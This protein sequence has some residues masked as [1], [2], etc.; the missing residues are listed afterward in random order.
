MSVKLTAPSSAKKGTS[1]SVSVKVTNTLGYHSSF[2][3]EIW[4]EATRIFNK[5]EII[6]DGQSKT[7]SDSFIMPASDVTVLAWVERWIFDHWGYY[8]AD[9]ELVELYTPPPPEPE[10]EF[11]GLAIS[12]F[13]KV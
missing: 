4:V 5:S 9:S 6:L 2:L 3:T 1:V 8:G 12:S 13:S 10:P 7:Y 11:S